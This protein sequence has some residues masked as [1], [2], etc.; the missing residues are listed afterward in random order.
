VL[1]TV[2]IEGHTRC[3]K[4]YYEALIAPLNQLQQNAD[5]QDQIAEADGTVTYVPG[6]GPDQP[7]PQ[8]WLKI[9]T[10]SIPE[11]PARTGEV[12]HDQTFNRNRYDNGIPLPP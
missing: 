1:F 2:K 7:W 3:S 9:D 11:D 10:Q 4:A 6:P 8:Y 5:A 12:S